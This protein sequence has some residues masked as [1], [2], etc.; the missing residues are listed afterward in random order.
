[1]GDGRGCEVKSPFEAV[2]LL[3]PL[4][5]RASATPPKNTKYSLDYVPSDKFLQLSKVLCYAVLPYANQ[6]YEVY[7]A[8]GQCS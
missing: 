3:M 7:D 6:Y 1:M 2:Q 8:T 4:G 5:R